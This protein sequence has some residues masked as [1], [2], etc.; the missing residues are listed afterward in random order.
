MVA[1]VLALD[2]PALCGH[3]NLGVTLLRRLL[4]VR[5]SARKRFC[6]GAFLLLVPCFALLCLAVDAVGGAFAAA[7]KR[8]LLWSYNIV[9]CCG[10]AVVRAVN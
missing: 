1:G 5:H 4:R 3:G 6:S 2:Q 9:A 7:R 10:F 8:V